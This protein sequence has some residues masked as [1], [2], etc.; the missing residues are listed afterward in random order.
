MP[1]RIAAWLE[2][3]LNLNQVRINARGA[4]PEVDS[5]LNAMRLVALT[6]RTTVTGS[7]QA[8]E[9]EVTRE[10]KWYSTTEAAERLG[11][12]DRAVRLAIKEKRLHATNLDGRW[13]ITTEDIEH[14]KAAKAA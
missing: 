9:P 2:R 11:I 4:D 7:S 13:R 10:S 6:W 1:A 5:V 14:F 8:P 3:N 12:T